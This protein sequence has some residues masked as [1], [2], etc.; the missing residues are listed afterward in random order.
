M[1][2][3]YIDSKPVNFSEENGRLFRREIKI[4][5]VISSFNQIINSSTTPH[6]FIITIRDYFSPSIIALVEK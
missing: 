3:V 6:H 1:L 2:L 4:K 5:R